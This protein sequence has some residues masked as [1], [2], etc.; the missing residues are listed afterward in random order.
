[1]ASKIYEKIVEDIQEKIYKGI[2]T[3]GG[4]LPSENNLCKEHNASRV[5]VRK[6]LSI[7]YER[8]FLYSVPGKGHFIRKPTNDSHILHFNEFDLL[9]DKADKITLLGV[10]IILP[11][12]E[13]MKKLEVNE[14]RNIVEIRRLFSAKRE[15]LAYDVKYLPYNKKQP[16][17]E[18]V[19]QYATFPELVSI[20]APL[21]CQ[22]KELIISSRTANEEEQKLLH[23]GQGYSLLVVEQKL[24]SDS[25]KPVGWGKVL[26]KGDTYFL[27]AISSIDNML[28]KVS[29]R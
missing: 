9:K 1:M 7:L 15:P 17:V 3:P 14:T 13:V 22:K 8:G 21:Y 27:R 19:I 24:L 25:D 23:V 28:S 18:E 6:A 10:R 2:Y 26:Y 20:N 4:M 16:L 29:Y 5:T 11:T 12:E